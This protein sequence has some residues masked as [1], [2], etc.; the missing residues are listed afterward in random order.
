MLFRS[1][2]DETGTITG[3]RFLPPDLPPNL[4]PIPPP[5]LPRLA[6]AARRAAVVA[7]AIVFPSALA[8]GFAPCETPGTPAT[9]AGRGRLPK[10]L[11]MSFLII[12]EREMTPAARAGMRGERGV[13]VGRDRYGHMFEQRDIVARIA[14]EGR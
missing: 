7:L 11:W 2:C 8:S 4:P 5:N 12:E 3:P 13:G 9:V 10:I 14:V 1:A 6:R